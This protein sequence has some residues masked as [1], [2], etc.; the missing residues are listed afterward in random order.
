MQTLVFLK[1]TRK[2]EKAKK[3]KELRKEANFTSDKIYFSSGYLNSAVFMLFLFYLKG[4]IAYK[5]EASLH[6]KLFVK[7]I[8]WMPGATKAALSLPFSAGQRRENIMKGS[9]VKI[10]T[11]RS[12]TSCCHGQNRSAWGTQFNLFP[13]KS[14]W[15][16]EK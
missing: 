12:L 7:Q 5:K 2:E 14:E 16:Y 10:R 9:W 8:N 1:R 6:R 3:S 11:R 13:I 4:K 15:D